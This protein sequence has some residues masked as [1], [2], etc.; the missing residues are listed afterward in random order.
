MKKAFFWLV[1]VCSLFACNNAKTENNG[2]TATTPTSNSSGSQQSGMPAAA[3]ATR[4]KLTIE[5][6]EYNHGGSLIVQKDKD[7]LQPGND[8]LVMLTAPANSSKG[9]FSL[10]FLMALHTGSYPVVGMG[11]TRGENTDAQMFGGILGG[12][13]KLTGYHVTI[14]ECNDLGSNNMGGHRWSISGNF[15]EL[16]IP[17]MG[18][19]L[20]DKTKNHPKEIKIDKG[21]FTKLSFDDNWEDL[22]KKASEQLKK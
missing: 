10:N 16:V 17:A 5:G 20:M 14:T 6:Q 3:P 22:I 12:Q 1:T 7:K 19:M 9:S 8:Y 11:Y 21:S 2:N 4:V 18:I 15:T 13:P